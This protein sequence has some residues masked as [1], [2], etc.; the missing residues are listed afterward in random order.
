MSADGTLAL[1]N[2]ALRDYETSSDAMR[3][4]PDPERVAPDPAL[5]MVFV[6]FDLGPLVRGFQQMSEAL[7]RAVIPAFHAA[8]EPVR[9]MA[10]AVDAGWYPRQHI[11]CHQCH[12]MANPKP[13]AVNGAQYRR[14]QKARKRR[15]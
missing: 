7:A 12:P 9:Q 13:L 8:I 10:H 2:G 3:W 5:P 1:I 11:R 6:D 15:R 14:R 4:S